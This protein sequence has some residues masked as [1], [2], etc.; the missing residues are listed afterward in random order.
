M[1]LTIERKELLD[2]LGIV[3]GAAANGGRPQ[4][5]PILSH[6]LINTF[7]KSVEFTCTDLDLVLR[8]KA[9]ADIHIKGAITVPVQLLHDLVRGIDGESLTLEVVTH[10]KQK[11]LRVTCGDG[12]YKLATL[13]VEEFP[14]APRLRDAYEV[15][16]SQAALR[17]LLNT[18]S[19]AAA[20]KDETRYLLNSTLLRV[21]GDLTVVGCDNRKLAMSSTDDLEKSKHKDR[22]LIVPANAI[23]VLL[24]L[25]EDEDK[26]CRVAA[27]ENLVQF[28]VGDTVLTSKLFAGKYPDIKD[29]IPET[30][31][32]GIAINRVELLQALQRCALFSDVCQLEFKDQNLTLRTVNRQQKLGEALETLLVT[33]AENLRVQVNAPALSEALRA[34]DADEIQFFAKANSPVT[35]KVAGQPWLAVFAGYA[36]EKPAAPQAENKPAKVTEAAVRK[37]ESKV[38]A[39]T[40]ETK[41]VNVTNNGHATNGHVRPVAA[42]Q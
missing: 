7:D 16:V 9:D 3:K 6:V 34:V 20:S 24:R 4:G 18:T 2:A 32:R 35:V 1:K 29:I 42:R 30:K 36:E 33:T 31:G 8:A 28:H 17:S 23:A 39:P 26:K 41:P 13:P 10:N 15:Q 40:R 5:L 19:F 25:L 38:P 27:A 22:D 12:E 11:V 14:P 21:N 37:D